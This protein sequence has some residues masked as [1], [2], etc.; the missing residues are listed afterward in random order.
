MC[1]DEVQNALSR[2]SSRSSVPSGASSTP[3][4]SSRTRWC[5]GCS[6]A[7]PA[8]RQPGAGHAAHAD[9]LCRADRLHRVRRGRWPAAPAGRSASSPRRRR[10]CRARAAIRSISPSRVR[11]FR[12]TMR[13]PCR[14]RWVAARSSPRRPS[15]RLWS[16]AMA[17]MEADE[18]ARVT[19]PNVPIRQR[20]RRNVPRLCGSRL[21]LRDRRDA[22]RPSVAARA[23]SC[24]HLHAARDRR[25]PRHGRGR[26][27]HGAARRS[28]SWASGDAAVQESRER[29]RAA[30]VNSGFD[31]PL[32]ADHGEPRSGGPAQGGPGVRS[33]PR[34]R[35][36]RGLRAGAAGA[37]RRPRV[38]R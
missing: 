31:F 30:L 2:C 12:S 17:P 32:Q 6:V 29:V 10:A 21:L 8:V 5:R 7:L 27:P 9:A 19:T 24:D 20:A 13:Q 16:P 38:L 11:K 14:W 4:T 36:A 18:D 23:G 25:H 33:R 22:R 34:G 1:L 28:R 37:S 35:A 3:I 26:H 15:A